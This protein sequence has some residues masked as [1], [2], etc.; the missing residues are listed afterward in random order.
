M[1][2]YEHLIEAEVIGLMTDGSGQPTYRFQVELFRRWVDRYA[3]RVEE[4]GASSLGA[5]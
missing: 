5:R 1:A 2:R 4:M 3:A